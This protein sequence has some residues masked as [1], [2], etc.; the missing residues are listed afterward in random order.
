MGAI[1]AV[2]VGPK[3]TDE[4]GHKKPISVTQYLTG[5]DVRV[6]LPGPKRLEPKRFVKSR[7]PHE[8]QKKT[9]P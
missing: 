5:F 7:F 4:R 2:P 1:A 8:P 9:S 3:K 6:I